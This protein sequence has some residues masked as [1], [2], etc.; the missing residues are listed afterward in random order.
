MITASISLFIIAAGFGLVVLTSI[1]QNKP[2]PK[3]FVYAHGAIAGLALLILLYYMAT[4]P[5]NSPI[6]S[7]LFFL[8]AA[9]GGFI[10]Y[11]IDIQGK[12]VPKWLALIHPVIALVALFSLGIF[13]I[14]V[15]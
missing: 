14:S 10:M 6:V 1:L 7:L 4:H 2:T 13:A 8:V 3:F 12:P 5:S 9:F 15:V 11:F